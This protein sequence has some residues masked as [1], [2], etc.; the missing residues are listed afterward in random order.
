MFWKS[1]NENRIFFSELLL[2]SSLLL[3]TRLYS[4]GPFLNLLDVP[5]GSS[6]ETTFMV[7]QSISNKGVGL[8]AK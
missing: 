2:K 7:R 6:V 3:Q 4:H 8:L 5:Y 1:V